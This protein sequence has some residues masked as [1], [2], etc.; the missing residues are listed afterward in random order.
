MRIDRIP[1][2]RGL[3]VVVVALASLWLNA[4]AVAQ[5]IHEDFVVAVA[6]DR[7][8]D[9]KK[10]LARGIDPNSVDKNGDPALVVAARAGYVATVDALLAGRANPNAKNAY[11]D[12]PLMAAALG[13]YL[14]VAKKLRAAGANVNVT[15]WSPLIYAATGGRDNVVVWLLGEGAE[16]N[17]V[18]PNGTTALMM[19]VRENKLTTL[20]LL[21]ARGANP[22]I[23]NQSDASALD[24]AKRN[25]D[26]VMIE[27]LKKAGA[28]D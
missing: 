21:L 13:G 7:A 20:D 11:G 19:A 10:L 25:E 4:T 6:N 8:E 18:S 27:R 2:S 28:R 9:V 14:D 3:L 26:K 12:T 24:W 16:I 23:R 1:L 5:Q 15:G 22:N 17:A